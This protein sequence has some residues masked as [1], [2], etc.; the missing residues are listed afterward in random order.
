M[1][2]SK[3]LCKCAAGAIP[4]KAGIPLGVD[5]MRVSNPWIPACA[6]TTDRRGKSPEQP[7]SCNPLLSLC[8]RV[9]GVNKLRF[10]GS[11]GDRPL[12][13]HGPTA[14]IVYRILFALLAALPVTGCQT[15]GSGS[16]PRDRLGYA[17]AIAE[18][19][20]EQMLLNI[21]KQ[22]YLDTPVYLDVSSII[23]SYSLA[24]AVNLG[25]EIYPR[26]SAGNSARLGAS[27]TFTDLPTI[28]YAPLTGERL[29][30]ALLRPIPPETVFA[31]IGGG[32]NAD[33]LL[34]ATLRSINAVHNASTMSPSA[35]PA[36]ARFTQVIGA[37]GRIEQGG[38][39]GLRIEKRGDDAVTFVVFHRDADADVQAAIRLVQDTLGLDP[40]RDEY[41]LV[42]GSARH[43]DEIAL[44][45]RSIQQILGELATGVDVPEADIA[46]GRATAR[47][48]AAAADASA[49]MRIHSGAERPTDAFAAVPYRNHWFWIDDRDLGSKRMFVFLTMFMSLTES[50]ALPQAPVLTLPVR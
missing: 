43:A 31:M 16:V 14:R 19:W 39:L 12:S 2:A 40:K 22:R 27:G 6:G 50:G 49:L 8:L 33:F 17:G 10:L 35:R 26:A 20:K 1:V 34:R 4:A 47:G 25:A 48:S 36:D 44:N 15:L 46:E 21:V 13:R 3:K 41:R 42:F 32:R 37:L 18:S 11:T 7:S 30:N 9:S 28:S 23:S 38:A 24:T 5:L 29:V 45:T